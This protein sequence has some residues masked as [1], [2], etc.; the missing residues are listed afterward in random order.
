V[1]EVLGALS[2]LLNGGG[3]SQLHIIVTQLNN[4]LA[5]NE[6]QIRALLP[7]LSHLLANL[8]AHRNDITRALDG[9][10]K[11]S[12]TL[13]ARDRQIGYV[14][15]NLHPGLRVLARQHQQLVT[16]LNSLHRL[17]GVAVATINGSQASLVADLQALA[18]TLQELA[19]AG[20]NL[21]LALQVLLTYPF[22]DQVL[23]DVKGDY[24]NTYLSV[25]APHGTKI[26]PPA[27]PPKKKRG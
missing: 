1:E 14:L 25:T 23:S 4:A 27:K 18:P 9:L 10:D 8:Y 2:L 5:S 12:A 3:I 22:T 19:S 13:R 26:I 24:L 17:T 21:P 15:T 11:L 6:P 16:M 7:Q 20:Q